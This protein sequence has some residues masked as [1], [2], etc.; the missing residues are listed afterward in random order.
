MTEHAPELVLD[1]PELR[2]LLVSLKSNSP[3]LGRAGFFVLL[4]VVFFIL[5]TRI[6]DGNNLSCVK[7]RFSLWYRTLWVYCWVIWISQ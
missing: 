5:N 1:P 6:P 7:F 3:L 2:P 4:G